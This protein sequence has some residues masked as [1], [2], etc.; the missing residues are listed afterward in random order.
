[1]EGTTINLFSIIKKEDV[2]I[3][4]VALLWIKQHGLSSMHSFFCCSYL[5]SSPIYLIMNKSIYLHIDLCDCVLFNA[6]LNRLRH[7]GKY[8]DPWKK[9]INNF[10]ISAFRCKLCNVKLWHVL[11]PCLY[12]LKGVLE[13]KSTPP[14]AKWH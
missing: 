5:Y 3:K 2:I 1:M 4:H 6:A 7:V 12:E 11:L 9:Y 10:T 8:N 13:F 14:T